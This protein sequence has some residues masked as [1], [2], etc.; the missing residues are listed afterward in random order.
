MLRHALKL[1]WNRRRSNLLVIVE[2]ALAFVAAFAVLA[3]GAYYWANY[4]RPMGLQYKDV[5]AVQLKTGRSRMQLNDA[6]NAENALTLRDVL[7]A[8]REQP[9][10][11]SAHVIRVTPFTKRRSNGPYLYENGKLVKTAAVAMTTGA[12]EALGAQLVQGRWFTSA[13]EGQAHRVAVVNQAYVDRAFAPGINPLQRNINHLID[14]PPPG[15]DDLPQFF[16]REINIVGVVKHLR[17]SD[18]AE[19]VPMVVIQYEL[20]QVP[21]NAVEHPNALFV[22]VQPGATAKLEEQV[23]RAIKSVAPDWEIIITPW[24]ELRRQTHAQILRP[25]AIG[26]T[27]AAFALLMVAMGLIGVIGMDVLRRTQEIGLRRAIGATAGSVRGQIILEMLIVGALGILA[28]SLVAIQFP[29]LAWVDQINWTSAM[30]G[31]VLAA[32]LILLLVALSALYPSF[33]ASRREPSEALRY[34]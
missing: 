20:E 2:I 17:N 14:H 16:H 15:A 28:G 5:W 27:V 29:L 11:A 31:L 1:I 33:M 30:S 8:V 18:L 26:A 10:V 23:I 13:D 24:E 22:K 32:G 4:H 9:G 7:V 34:E 19:E 21:E 3:L 25:V 12:L 6:W